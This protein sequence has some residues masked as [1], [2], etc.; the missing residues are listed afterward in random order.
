[1]VF[2]TTKRK[3]IWRV[4][5]G[6]LG[7]FT[8]APVIPGSKREDSGLE[9]RKE[10]MN[11]AK[12]IEMISRGQSTGKVAGILTEIWRSYSHV[13][14]IVAYSLDRVEL[15]GPFLKKLPP[16]QPLCPTGRKGNLRQG[17]IILCYWNKLSPPCYRCSESHNG[18]G[19]DLSSI[20]EI[21]QCALQ[22]I[23][24]CPLARS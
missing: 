3:G 22:S 7:S 10:F 15:W 11:L 20:F 24:W 14:A 23:L 1:M 18:G 17:N 21:I 9:G 5:S 6:G 13:P 12:I 16:K 8:E 19:S 2:E 4:A